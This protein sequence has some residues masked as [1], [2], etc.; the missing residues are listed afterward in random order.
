MRNRSLLHGTHQGTKVTP[1]LPDAAQPADP[2]HDWLRCNCK[3]LL[4]VGQTRAT[5]PACEAGRGRSGPPQGCLSLVWAPGGEER[6]WNGERERAVAGFHNTSTDALGD[7]SL[8]SY[9]CGRCLSRLVCL[10]PCRPASNCAVTQLLD[11]EHSLES[12]SYEL[13]A[14]HLRGRASQQQS[15]D[16]WHSSTALLP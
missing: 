4:G 1:G 2:R 6:K 5:P 14:V 13:D 8:E 16:P 7:R 12:S 15:P 9:G 3:R 10:V 11:I